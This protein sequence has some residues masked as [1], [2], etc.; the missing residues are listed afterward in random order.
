MLKKKIWA[1][2]QRII[3]LFTKKLSK[4]SSKYGLGIRDPEKTHSGSR[5]QGSKRHR[6]PDPGSAT[7]LTA[8]SQHSWNSHFVFLRCPISSWTQIFPVH[9]ITFRKQVCIISWHFPFKKEVK[10]F[11]C[12]SE[13]FPAVRRVTCLILL[14]Y[15]QYEERLS[16]WQSDQP[17]SQVQND[18]YL[19]LL[20]L[21]VL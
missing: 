16:S 5:I 18:R 21:P 6:I 7:L 13:Q 11:P 14:L 15:H 20:P 17:H 8:M 1:N 2:F 3:E 10:R 12:I 19:N 4:S 9:S